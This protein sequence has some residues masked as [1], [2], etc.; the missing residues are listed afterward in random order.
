MSFWRPFAFHIPSIDSILDRQSVTLEDVLDEEQVLQETKNQNRKLMN[1][2]SQKDNLKRMINYITT[3]AEENADYKH[4][5]RYPNLS[6]EILSLELTHFSDI[7]YDDE[8]LLDQ[9]Y[10]FILIE[11]ETPSQSAA[12]LASYASK[13]A[14]SLMQF[15]VPQTVEYLKKKEII[16]KLVTKLR[17]PPSLDVLLKVIY[18][19]HTHMN[20]ELGVSQILIENEMIPKLIDQFNTDNDH[21]SHEAAAQ[22][23]VELIT[24]CSR[25]GS[26]SP[27][28]NQLESKEMS[29]KLFAYALAEG[30]SSELIHGLAVVIELLRR[31]SLLQS[32][33][34][35]IPRPNLQ[36][37]Y[38]MQEMGIPPP[39]PPPPPRADLDP[40]TLP[41][42]IETTLSYLPV[43]MGII[44]NTAPGEESTV[45]MPLGEQRVFGFRRYKVLET[46]ASLANTGFPA[47]FHALLHKNI[48][49]ACLDIFFEFQWNNFVHATVEQMI[50]PLATSPLSFLQLVKDF[51]LAERIVD[52]SNQNHS[53]EESSQAVVFRRGYMG[54]VMNLSRLIETTT[55]T[56]EPLKAFLQED[57]KWSKYVEGLYKETVQR[58]KRPFIPSLTQGPSY[59]DQSN[60]EFNQL[61]QNYMD[62]QDDFTDFLYPDEGELNYDGD[63]QYEYQNEN[64][65]EDVDSEDD[66]EGDEDTDEEEEGGDSDEEHNQ[67]EQT[68]THET[69]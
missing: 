14:C 62:F 43:M 64:H 12:I 55:S 50:V 16:P 58:Q 26:N 34:S 2:L 18:C 33:P 23:L 65:Y 13:V 38:G 46:I 68:P 66:S 19:E 25:A 6:S 11:K 5:V 22:A 40:N 37:Q 1:F 48:Y 10:S 20:L 63:R 44:Q 61:D 15:K 52:T 57:E 60:P 51:K 35:S 41:S 56:S 53:E 67:V 21:D 59:E 30:S 27:I 8:S 24:I 39:T 28:L 9:L 3:E 36:N 29:T 54:H 47:V 69:L 49:S 4:R 31:N 32:Q 45:K 17:N 7:I 42:F